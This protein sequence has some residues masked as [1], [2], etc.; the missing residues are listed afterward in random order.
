MVLYPVDTL[1]SLQT[2]LIHSF[3]SIIGIL[4]P[5]IYSFVIFVVLLYLNHHN[6]LH[7]QFLYYCFV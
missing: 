3:I 1:A 4:N 2:Q 6:F 7:T 5:T